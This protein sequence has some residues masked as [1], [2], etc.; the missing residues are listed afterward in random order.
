[1]KDLLPIASSNLDGAK[2][3]PT[4]KTLT[5][6]FKSGGVYEYADVP[7]DIYDN[8][9]ATFQTKDSSGKFFLKHVKGFPFKKVSK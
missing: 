9:A 2:Y 1:M 4:S 8:F 3:D 6:K 5:V 7:S